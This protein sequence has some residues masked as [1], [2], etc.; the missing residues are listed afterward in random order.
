M[1]IKNFLRKYYSFSK[2]EQRGIMV[3]IALILVFW[4]LT[5]VIENHQRP[6]NVEYINGDTISVNEIRTS[7][8]YK[9]KAKDNPR[10]E[11]TAKKIQL[12]PF[13]PNLLEEEGW[14]KL[15]LPARTIKA[16][17]AYRKAGGK[18]NKPEDLKR[19]YTLTP[20]DYQRIAPYV[21]IE[22]ARKDSIQSLATRKGDFSAP[23][24]PIIDLNSA[25]TLLLQDLPGIGS[26]F[27]RRIWKYGQRLGGYHHSEQLLE[28]YGMDASRLEKI[29]PYIIIDTTK[30]RKID[31]N[32]ASF[33]DLLRHPYLEY[34]MV[35]A[36]ADYRHKHHGIKEISELKI[37]PLMYDELYNKLRPYLAINPEY[38][39]SQ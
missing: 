33:K 14:R 2:R 37:L 16:I 24:I 18:F 35:K 3:L 34:Y 1:G 26:T 39:I 32:Q 25:D 15:G 13:D 5:L 23:S 36:I 19:I 17:L 6:V 11:F 29:K 31:L 30:I 4:G 28:V 20:D 8:P 7:N 9:E 38:I 21:V 22:R 12:F 27:A 10:L